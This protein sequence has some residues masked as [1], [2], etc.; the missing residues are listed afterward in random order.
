MMR[1][2]Q[3]GVAVVTALLMTA[4]AVSIVAGL[5]WQQQVQIRLVDNQRLRIQEEWQLRDMLD[6]AQQLLV[7]D[8]R[9]S[10]IDYEGE[11][12]SRPLSAPPASSDA[13]QAVLQ[14]TLIDAQGRFNLTNLSDEG[15]IDAIETATFARLLRGQNIGAQLAQASAQAIAELQR[16]NAS[17]RARMRLWQ[18]DDLLAIPGF[19]SSML[20]RLRGLVVVLPEST[21]INVNTAPAEVIAALYAIPL[22][23]ATALVAERRR[24]YFRDAADFSNR[25]QRRNLPEPSGQ[26]TFASHF[27]L[28]NGDVRIGRATLQTQALIQRD[29]GQARVLWRRDGEI[30]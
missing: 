26:I 24:A 20:R 30:S 9:V 2:R 25:M 27:F 8:D 16:S 5:F 12:W 22:A 15:Q 11:A 13:A 3:C 17:G 1:R 4:L 23:E 14:G 29:S 18:L 19:N 10:S 6:R 7:D 21:P 28:V